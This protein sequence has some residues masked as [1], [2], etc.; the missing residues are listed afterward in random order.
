MPAAEPAGRGLGRLPCTGRMGRH[1]PPTNR[2]LYFSVAASTLRFALIVALVV[3]GVVVINQAFPEGV[4]SGDSSGTV[5]DPGGPAVT[6][7][8]SP[9][10]S[11]T[12]SPSANVPSPTISGTLIAVFNGTSVT[13][14]AADVQTDLEGEGYVQAQEV[15]DAPSDVAV[16]TLYYRTNKD[17]VEAENLANVYFKKLE[18]VV[19][20]KLGQ[21][22][23]EVG[24]EVQVAIF[25]GNDY[26]ALK[27]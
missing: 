18:G 7:S 16:T 11:Q 13:G 26:A 3:G 15:A 25:L 27:S 20:A 23:T 1:E 21:S 19:V 12:Q 6:E 24:S 5:P 9:T 2:S 22:E 10:A 4:S 8:P 17:K 14:L